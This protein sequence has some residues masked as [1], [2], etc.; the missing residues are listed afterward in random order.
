MSVVDDVRDIALTQVAAGLPVVAVLGL[1]TFLMLLATAAYGISL[2]KGWI[3]GSIFFHR[4]MGLLTIAL[5]IVHAVL[6]LSTFL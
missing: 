3:R 1:A 2:L 6:A 5:A 4:N